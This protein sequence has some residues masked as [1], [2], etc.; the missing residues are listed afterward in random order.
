MF[1]L[2]SEERGTRLS[3]NIIWILN[4]PLSQSSFSIF[5]PFPTYFSSSL[6]FLIVQLHNFVWAHL[7]PHSPPSLLSSC[8]SF[9]HFFAFHRASSKSFSL[10]VIAHFLYYEHTPLLAVRLLHCNWKSS[11][12][13][14]C[15][16]RESRFH[17]L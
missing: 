13:D 9:R 8:S 5:F 16:S 6:L 2:V 7:T 15:V 14:E 11:L 1:T 17:C 10:I 3:E 12:L 4:F